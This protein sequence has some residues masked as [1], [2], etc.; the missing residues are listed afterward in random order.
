ML[1]E[2]KLLP[3]TYRTIF[4]QLSSP[5]SIDKVNSTYAIRLKNGKSTY[6]NDLQPTRISVAKTLERT[7]K[8]ENPLTRC[9]RYAHTV[10]FKKLKRDRS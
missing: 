4:H 10:V 3:L 5:S 9:S 2:G 7:R 1:H 6:D 8:L